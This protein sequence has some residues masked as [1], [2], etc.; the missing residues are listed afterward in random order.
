MQSRQ[1]VFSGG[2]LAI[3][4]T[5][6]SSPVSW[7]QF[8]PPMNSLSLDAE[9]KLEG[10]QGG[11]LQFRDSSNELW[12]IQ[13]SPQTTVTIVGEADFSYLRPGMT[14][15][16]TGNI[17]QDGNFAEPISEVQII[18]AKGRPALG[19]FDPT[20]DGAKPVRDPEPGQYRVRGRIITSKNG[21][22]ELIAGRLKIGGTAAPEFKAVLEFDD[23]RLAQIGDSLKVKAWY[24][25]TWRP[26]PTLNRPG[27]AL[28][29]S[30]DI[31]L[32]N[33]PISNKRGR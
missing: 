9:G 19:L 22:L 4:L 8:Q 32:A 10:L 21:E 13:I 33:P 12:L 17:N 29:E 31:T 3:C 24:I 11:V 1:I 27:K 2:V 20:D 26:I 6:F 14:I 25:E 16:L 5:L 7:A 15:E 30:L 23:S 18:N 28:A